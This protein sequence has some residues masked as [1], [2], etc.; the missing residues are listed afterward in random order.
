MAR[1][2]AKIVRCE[3]MSMNMSVSIEGQE[4]RLGEEESV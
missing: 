3:K 4:E 2:I 1:W